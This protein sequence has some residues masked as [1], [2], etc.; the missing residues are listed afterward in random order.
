M[1]VQSMKKL[2]LIVIMYAT[3]NGSSRA[4][5]IFSQTSPRQPEASFASSDIVD[6]QK[7][8]DNFLISGAGEYTV[9]SLR[10]IGGYG[11][12]T[13]PT[14]LLPNDDFRIVFLTDDGGNPGALV[15]GGSFSINSVVSRKATNGPLLNGVGSPIEIDIDLGD[16]IT[17]DRGNEYWISVSNDPTSGSGWAWARATGLLD[18]KTAS[19]F[20]DVSFGVWNISSSGGMWFELSTENIPEPGS[21]LLILLSIMPM[22]AFVRRRQPRDRPNRYPFE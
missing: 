10:V 11:T 13:N 7:M 9:R 17:L 22:L 12:L 2:L 3:Y 1:N 5:I 15:E 18:Q 6:R 19:T 8:A 16:G 14:E 4:A 21:T 20:G